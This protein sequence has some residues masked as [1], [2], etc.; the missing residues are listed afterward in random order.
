IVLHDWVI[1]KHGGR[2]GIHDRG[3]LES[4]LAQPQIQLAN[5]YEPYPSLAEKAAA[6]AFFFARNGPFSDGNKR[7]AQMVGVHLLRKN[8]LAH[9]Y[10]E[11]AIADTIEAVV[12]RRAGMDDLVALFRAPPPPLT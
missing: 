7:T 3:A 10:D 9:V 6:Y 1:D 11:D 5:G 2:P 8:G 12:V 4:C